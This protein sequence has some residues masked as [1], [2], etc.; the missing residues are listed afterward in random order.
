MVCP[1]L[2][3]WRPMVMMRSAICTPSFSGLIGQIIP[4]RDAAVRACLSVMP[5][6]APPAA[7]AGGKFSLTAPF[8]LHYT[9]KNRKERRDDAEVFGGADPAGAAAAEFQPGGPVPGRVCRE[10]S[11]QDR[12]GQG[13]GG[14]GHPPASA[15]AAGGGLRDGPGLSGPGGG[16][17]GDGLP[18]AAVGAGEPGRLSGGP[19]LAGGEPGAVPP[20]PLSVGRPAAAEPPPG[21]GAGAGGVRRRHGPAAVRPLSGPAAGERGGERGGERPGGAAAPGRQRLLYHFRRRALH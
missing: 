9:E 4:H 20:L 6:S 16:G 21:P 12:A 5:I 11:Q 14:G 8:P 18:G 7:V 1:P 15:A 13:G 3:H 17:G 10:L 2:P 19:D